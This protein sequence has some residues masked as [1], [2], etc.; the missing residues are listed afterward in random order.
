MYPLFF[1]QQLFIEHLLKA[2]IFEVLGIEKKTK[3]TK[4][5]EPL[6]QWRET[7]NI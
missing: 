3:D 1:T 6:F 5:M 4:I 7:N 2:G